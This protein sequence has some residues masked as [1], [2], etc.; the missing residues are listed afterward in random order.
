MASIAALVLGASNVLVQV[1]IAILLA[2]G[3]EPAVAW[4]RGKTG[5]ARSVNIMLVYLGFMVL[6]G[7]AVVPHR[8]RRQ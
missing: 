8:A 1:A 2:A 5:L 7:L 3:L 4:L 6:V